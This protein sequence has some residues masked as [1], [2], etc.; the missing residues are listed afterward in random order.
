[1]SWRLYAD[2]GNST[3]KFAARRN[4]EWASV[5]HVSW[6]EASENE[7]LDSGTFAVGRLLNELKL[8]KLATEDC[9]A[10]VCLGSDP[11]AE[12]V[13]EMLGDAFDKPVR[14]LGKSLKA[15]LKSKYRPP[16]SLGADRVAN[17]VG[18]YALY[19]GPVIVL[20]AGS[21]LTCEI[22]DAG[23]TF[24]GGFIGAGMPALVEGISEV[25]PVLAEAWNSED[26]PEDTLI[27]QSTAQS[28]MVGTILQLQ[29]SVHFYIMNAREQLA[30]PA[31]QVV[32][33]GGMGE[34]LADMYAEDDPRV[35][36]N[37]L[38]T[39]EGLRIIDGFE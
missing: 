34:P 38:L 36:G 25:A 13:F 8:A 31:A 20:D 21:C 22:V 33:T 12:M 28:L 37:P 26:V 23:G 10:V 3:L 9:E 18:A 1:M 14:V 29:G 4:G 2:I 27:G 30:A 6:E 32:L 19:G 16:H 11:D 5:V 39:F 35:I 15:R 17:A 24:I 7:M